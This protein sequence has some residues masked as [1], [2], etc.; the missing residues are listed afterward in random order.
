MSVIYRLSFYS[1]FL[2]TILF[3]YATKTKITTIV[4]K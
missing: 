4:D 2:Q 3:V 1:N